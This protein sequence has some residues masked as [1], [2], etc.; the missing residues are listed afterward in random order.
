M[1][2]DA[3]LSCFIWILLLDV[4]S[5]F[6]QLRRAQQRTTAALGLY[7]ID[8]EERVADVCIL[9]HGESTFNALNR[10]CGWADVPL[11]ATGID[12]AKT[13][14][15]LIREDPYLGDVD[16]IFTSNLRRASR[17]A[18]LVAAELNQRNAPRIVQDWRL[19]EQMYGALTGLNKRQAM[20]EFGFHQVQRWRRGWAE[21]PPSNIFGAQWAFSSETR[22]GCESPSRYSKCDLEEYSYEKR[23][24][25]TESFM[26]ISKRVQDFWTDKVVPECLAGRRVA[27][28][29]HGNM[30]RALIQRLECMPHKD[31]AELTIPRCTP[32]HYRFAAPVLSYLDEDISFR[33]PRA[34]ESA[35][36][37]GPLPEDVSNSDPG[38][39]ILPFPR[40]P[41]SAMVP[42]RA[43]MLLSDDE[44]TQRLHQEKL[45]L[46]KT[47]TVVSSP[48]LT[49]YT[50]AR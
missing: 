44:V 34:E 35:A 43:R 33:A 8:N 48:A 49:N 10:F 38:L 37:E 15:S 40:A 31:I 24:D 20:L 29:G 18:H 30:L 28:V 27:I 9:R 3:V 26:D 14:G 47:A 42:L 25:G 5:G 41:S 22:P 16:V 32:L 13:A 12:E 1:R 21:A 7:K 11:T 4:G 50:L 17:T 6:S 39:E 45:S 46:H 36:Q 19:N 2:R 23:L